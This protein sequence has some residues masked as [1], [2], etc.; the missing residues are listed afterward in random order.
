MIKLRIDEDS[1]F[2][3]FLSHLTQLAILGKDE[4]QLLEP[5]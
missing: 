1:F 2:L 3:I 4:S 5:V